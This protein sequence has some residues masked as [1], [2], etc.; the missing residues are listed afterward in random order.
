MGAG[1]KRARQ[2]PGSPRGHR[3][4]GGG[5]S[6]RAARSGGCG[7]DRGSGDCRLGWLAG[8]HLSA[9][10]SSWIRR[11]GIGM[12]LAQA[13]ENYAA[14]LWRPPRHRPRRIRRSACGLFLGRRRL[15]AGHRDRPAR[16]KHLSAPISRLTPCSKVAEAGDEWLP[17]RWVAV[18]S[19]KCSLFDVRVL[20]SRVVASRPTGKRHG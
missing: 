13:A 17:N 20:A 19:L 16:K 3:A 2:H 14:E 15:S 11:R 12:Q 18:L 5:L 7:T 4:V 9:C 8:K 1:P 6:S 10:R